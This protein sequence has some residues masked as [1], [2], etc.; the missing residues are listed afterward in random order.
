M[1]IRVNALRAALATAMLLLVIPAWVSAAG[2]DA[3]ASDSAAEAAERDATVP[4][5]AV[6]EDRLIEEVTRRVVERLR[7]D[8]MLE[9]EIEKG[10]QAFVQKQRE[11]Q[12][13][14]RQAR[15]QQLDELAKNVR[16]VDPQHDH[17]AG[18]PDAVLSLI[19]YSDFECPFCKRFHPNAQRFVE[20]SNGQVNW[21]YRHFPLAM[22][23]PGAQKQ[24]EASECVA[25][26]AG[27]DA[28]WRFTDAIYER[29]QAGGKGFPLDRLGPLAAEIG[30]DVEQF[31]RCLDS[32]EQAE[33]VEQDV[34]E[35]TAVGVTGTPA[36]FLRN[37]E[38]GEVVVI[39]GAASTAALKAAADGLL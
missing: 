14:A 3:A 19:E 20:D 18:N 24:A 10:I 36:N 28:F 22:H 7:R 8:G 27:N 39:R 4:I 5:I 13:N 23:N 21:V 1:R 9:D 37:N 11:R 6:D 30:L 26:L 35:G 25:K 15:E 17:I 38:T 33:R 32:G 34:T 2:P 31:T 29:T 12:Q 16:P